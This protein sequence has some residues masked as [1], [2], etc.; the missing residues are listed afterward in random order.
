MQGWSEGV[1]EAPKAAFFLPYKELL[2][3]EKLE[4][5]GDTSAGCPHTLHL[6]KDWK[7][8]DWLVDLEARDPQKMQSNVHLG[9]QVKY[10]SWSVL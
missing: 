4:A 3:E 10:R 5:F 2:G 9:D 7:L 8:D 1:H 6:C